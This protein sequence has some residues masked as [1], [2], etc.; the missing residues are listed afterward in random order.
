MAFDLENSCGATAGGP[1]RGTTPLIRPRCE[2]AALPLDA[3]T[4]RSSA[5]SASS[6][7]E[8][9]ANPVIPRTE[10]PKRRIPALGQIGSAGLQCRAS[11]LSLRRIVSKDPTELPSAPAS[12]LLG[13]ASVAQRGPATR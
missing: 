9:V 7:I 5:A 2:L 8:R 3:V 10:C 12:R 13:A 11:R 1:E 6:V 4:A